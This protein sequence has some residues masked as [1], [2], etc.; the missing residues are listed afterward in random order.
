MTLWFWI[1]L[2]LL[3][4]FANFVYAMVQIKRFLS[5]TSIIETRKNL[6]DFKHFVRAQ[7]YQTLVQLCFQ[8]GALLLCLFGIFSRNLR[9]GQI[10]LFLILN[11]IIIILG[12]IFR[13]TEDDAR[14]LLVEDED[15]KVEYEAVCQTWVKKPLPD[16]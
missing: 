6:E 14:S 3:L 13:K 15:L 4:S 8:G 16:F 12:R 2:L 1:L 9:F 10:L 11:G 5:H 7:M